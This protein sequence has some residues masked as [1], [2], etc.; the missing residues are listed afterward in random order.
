MVFRFCVPLD[1]CTFAALFLT[2]CLSSN[3]EHVFCDLHTNAEA[4]FA[5]AFSMLLIWDFLYF[6]VVFAQ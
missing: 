1:G 6:F 2:S 3:D 4:F 5:H